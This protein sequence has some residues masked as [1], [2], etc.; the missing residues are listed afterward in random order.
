[1]GSGETRGGKER[2]AVRIRREW[3]PREAERWT[4]EDTIAV[5]LSPVIYFLILIGCSLAFLLK[6]SG[7]VILAAAVVLT[8][9][10]IRIINPKL[11]AVSRNYE[12]KQKEYIEELEKKVKWRD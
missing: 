5:I 3:A 9:I 11:D 10:L 12:E 4:V 7:F 1:M 8:F 6:V 2:V